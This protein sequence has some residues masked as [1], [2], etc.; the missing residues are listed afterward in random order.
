MVPDGMGSHHSIF[1][2]AMTKYYMM[3]KVARQYLDLLAENRAKTRL[4]LQTCQWET[5]LT[6]YPH[7]KYISGAFQLKIQHREN[8]FKYFLEPSAKDVGNILPYSV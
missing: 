3:F 1:Q 2:V 6:T 5:R 4:D 7:R 8:V